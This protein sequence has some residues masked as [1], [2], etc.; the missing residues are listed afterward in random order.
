MKTKKTK[1]LHFK[2]RIYVRS[3]NVH[4]F[5]NAYVKKKN[6]KLS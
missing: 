1:Q 5:A 6:K 4:T 2:K 3:K